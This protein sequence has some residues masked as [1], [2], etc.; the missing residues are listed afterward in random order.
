MRQAYQKMAEIYD[1]LMDEKERL[2]WISSTL[3]LLKAHHVMPGAQVIDLA[4]GTGT[5]AIAL[6]DE[7]YR[8]TGIDASIDMLTQAQRKA[9]ERNILWINRD[10]RSF[11][12][13]LP[14]EAITCACDGVNYLTTFKQV[15]QCFFSV[16][17]ALI[18]G[19]LFLF[20]ISTPKKL[21]AMD[22]QLFALDEDETAYIW[23]NRMNPTTGVLTMDITFFQDRGDGLFERFE[24]IHRQRAHSREEIC[25]ALA[26][27][28]F[29]VRAVYGELGQ[30]LADDGALRNRY[31]AIKEK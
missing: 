25:R 30:S 9:G 27:Q 28:G 17:R 22:G 3:G 16:Y 14:V 29:A 11:R 19:G 12:V 26:N 8:V 10:M 31:L 6:A 1:R 21:T 7:G 23:R 24:E 18:P 5:I 4:C 20:D 15:E 13:P 2:R